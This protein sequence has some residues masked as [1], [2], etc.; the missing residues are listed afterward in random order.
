MGSEDFSFYLQKK[1]GCYFILGNGNNGGPLHSP[2]Y[3]FNDDA[4][5]FGAAAWVAIAEKALRVRE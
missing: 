2:T 3:D 5:K 4:L 1:P